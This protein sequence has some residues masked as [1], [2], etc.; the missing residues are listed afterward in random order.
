M[1]RSNSSST[2]IT[3]RETG[4]SP[5]HP[6]GRARSIDVLPSP[7]DY[8]YAPPGGPTGRGGRGGR[9]RRLSN[10]EAFRDPM[11]L[12]QVFPGLQ[13]PA[14]RS[15]IAVADYLFDFTGPASAL[16]AELSLRRANALLGEIRKIDPHYRVRSRGM[17]N[18]ETAEGWR[19]YL[20]GLRMD[21]AAALYGAR[22]ETGPL[23]VETI[24]FLRAR[25]DAAYA[26]G[27][28]RLKA[29]KID[30]RLSDRVGLGNFID[31]RVRNELRELYNMYGIQWGKE[32]P[33]RVVPRE[34]WTKGNER[35]FSV[36]DSRIGRVAFDMTLQQKTAGTPQ[37]RNFFGSDFQP[38][39]IIIVRPSQLGPGSTYA[40]PRPRK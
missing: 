15:V 28:K 40:I 16:N 22:G 13:S 23:Q 2:L 30:A 36:P 19:T 17:T 27:L 20:N 34:H 24:R 29:G 39:V 33:V 25:V 6:A 10:S 8:A 21:R 26:E 37:I 4:S 38:D 35:T 18:P 14:G 9:G 32:S 5:S 3:I 11:L 7:R 31:W 1:A 12:H